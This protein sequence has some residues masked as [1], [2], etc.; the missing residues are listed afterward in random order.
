MQKHSSISAI[1]FDLDGVILDSV[2]LKTNLFLRCYGDELTEE[3]KTYIRAHQARHGG[4]GRGEKFE[5]FELA[6]FGRQ[7]TPE[8]VARLTCLYGDFLAEEIDNCSYL[9]GAEA[10]L[11]GVEKDLPLHLVSGTLHEDL[12]R[13]LNDRNL[14]RHFVSVIGS[15]TRKLDALRA[16][17]AQE[18]YE[19]TTVL[20]I[21]DARTE[22][23]A[24]T[25][26][27]MQF[28][29]I[30]APSEPNAFPL[31]TPVYPNLAA[32]HA[33]WSRYTLLVPEDSSAT[34]SVGRNH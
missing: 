20:A 32:L 11:I 14:M 34:R 18:N 28:V 22:F 9:P 5:H 19:P 16:I 29:G 24:A 30:V 7:P 33:D 13:I 1:I 21:G 31:G 17:V 25:D 26:L 15:P 4:V 10:F 27:G 6:L 2:A 3:H 8:N 23:D 12:V